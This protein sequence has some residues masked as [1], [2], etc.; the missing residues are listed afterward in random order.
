[1]TRPPFVVTMGDPAGVGG[2]IVLQAYAKHRDKLPPFLVIDDPG[3]LGALALALKLDCSLQTI[4][5]PDE[6]A[7]FFPSAL[8]VL[9]VD[10]PLA[11][12]AELGTPNSANAPAIVGAIDTAVQFVQDG[13]AAALVTNPIHKASL[14]DHGFSHPGHTEYLGTLAGPGVQ[15]VMMLASDKVKNGLRVVPITIHLS[16]ADAARTLTTASIV[17][18]G[19]ITARALQK[20]FGIATPRLAMAALNPHAGESGKFGRE[21]IEIIGPAIEQLR[22]D[23]LTVTEPLPAD[24]LFHGDARASH[25]AVLCMYHDQA[26]IPIKTLDF[27]GGVNVTL[28]L[29]F[30]RTS[31][32]HGTAFG[33]AGTGQARCDS[34]VAAIQMADTIAAHRAAGSS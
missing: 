16:L 12:P 4:S 33:L 21:E 13:Q 7:R 8:P 14:Q 10:P 17:E 9:P 6:A 28:G 24:T 30:V 31:P 5:A 27:Y 11:E 3:R 34:L 2:D 18:H 19:R 32:D 22:D 26:L 20:D 15:P 29:P 1:M 25:D 23:G